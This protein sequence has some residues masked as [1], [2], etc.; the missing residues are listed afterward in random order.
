MTHRGLFQLLPFCDS[1]ILCFP[2]P[3]TAPGTTGYTGAHSPPF[4]ALKPG[5]AFGLHPK[6]GAPAET[7]APTLPSP[8]RC[9]ITCCRTCY[10]EDR[11]TL[12][13]RTREHTEFLTLLPRANPLWFCH[14]HKIPVLNC[15][16]FASAVIATMR[17]SHHFTLE[18]ETRRSR[19]DCN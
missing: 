6:R 13:A 17:L 14:G 18:A 7:S 10:G 16:S 11:T 1:V 2:F 15:F 8:L 12:A 9:G 19:G 5:V 3:V 4:C